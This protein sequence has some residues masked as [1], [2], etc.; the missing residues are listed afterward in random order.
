MDLV[1]AVWPRVIISKLS[2]KEMGSILEDL[3][4]R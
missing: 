3:N 2:L 4:S 1:N